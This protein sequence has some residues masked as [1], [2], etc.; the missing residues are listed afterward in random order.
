M[1]ETQTVSE[2]PNICSELTRLIA[3]VFI[4]FNRLEILT[5]SRKCGC[6]SLKWAHFM[7]VPI[8]VHVFEIHGEIH[9]ATKSITH[10]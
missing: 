7:A 8:S 1:R 5:F 2:A 10:L 6:A 9:L 3:L 4:V